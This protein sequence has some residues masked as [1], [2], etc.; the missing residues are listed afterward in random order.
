MVVSLQERQRVGAGVA[1][2]LRSG[3]IGRET[4]TG[5]EAADDLPASRLGPS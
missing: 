5:S 3:E 2:N 1:G 4:G